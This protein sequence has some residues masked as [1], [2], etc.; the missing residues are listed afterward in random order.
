VTSGPPLDVAPLLLPDEPPLVL[1]ETPPLLLPDTPPLLLP[2]TPPLPLPVTP[3]LLLPEDPPLLPEDP[4]LDDPPSPSFWFMV[5]VPCVP[6]TLPPQAAAAAATRTNGAQ[7]GEE[8]RRERF[9]WFSASR[10]AG[11]AS[12]G[13]DDIVPQGRAKFDPAVTCA[14]A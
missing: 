12:Q 3:P 10:R 13:R 4:P 6:A 11:R 1:P 9:I 7:R 8:S 14:V 5:F 2:V